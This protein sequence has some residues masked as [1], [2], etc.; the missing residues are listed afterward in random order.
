MNENEITQKQ[1]KLSPEKKYTYS[2]LNRYKN[3]YVL[4]SV[5]QVS[6]D[7]HIGIKQARKL[8]EQE[9]FPSIKIGNRKMISLISYTF[10]KLNKKL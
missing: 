10:W 6:K 5:E 7:L 4:L 8:F 3:P 1:S 2:Y 9:E